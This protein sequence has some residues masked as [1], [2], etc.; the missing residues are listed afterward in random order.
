MSYRVHGEA[1]ERAW[2]MS[3]LPLLIEESDWAEIV[4]GVTQRAS[5]IEALLADV[6]G[7]AAVWSPTASCRRRWSRAA[8]TICGRWSA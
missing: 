4:A 1:G 6:Y 5:V 2:P 8:A 7:E 3:R